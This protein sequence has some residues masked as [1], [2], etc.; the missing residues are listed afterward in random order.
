MKVSPTG[1]LMGVRSGHNLP[2]RADGNLPFR[3]TF[4]SPSTDRQKTVSEQTYNSIND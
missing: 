4:P 2:P 1:A 3:R